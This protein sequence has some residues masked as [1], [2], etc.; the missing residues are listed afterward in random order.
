MDIYFFQCAADFGGPRKE[1]FTLVLQEIKE[2]F[3]EPVR[4]L[5]EDYEVVGRIMGKLDLKSNVH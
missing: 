1:F 4:Q 5:S 3:F 2:N